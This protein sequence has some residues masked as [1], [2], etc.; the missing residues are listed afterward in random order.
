[1]T[2]QL[3]VGV[4]VPSGAKRTPDPVAFSR[5]GQYWAEFSRLLWVD[6]VAKLA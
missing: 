5:H 4:N 2:D 1:M 6:F 3:R